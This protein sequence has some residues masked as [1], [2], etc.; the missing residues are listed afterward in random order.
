MEMLVEV[1][2]PGFPREP[3]TRP[4][5]RRRPAL[6]VAAADLHVAELRVRDEN[7]VVEHSRSEARAQ[8][9]DEHDA[10]LADAGPES[11]LGEAGRIGVVEHL[12][13]GLERIPE[14]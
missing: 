1:A 12:D 9:Q 3:A 8:G 10:T 6:G 5:D 13:L 14:M 4:R 2:C 11:H 7:A